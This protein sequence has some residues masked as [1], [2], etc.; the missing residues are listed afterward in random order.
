MIGSLDFAKGKQQAVY[1]GSGTNSWP[2]AYS[3]DL[4]TGKTKLIDDSDAVNYAH[5]KLGEV[6]DWEFVSKR[7]QRVIG[8]YYLPP[9]F[10]EKKKYPTIV[11]YYGGTTPVGRDFG[12]RYPK[13]HYAANGFV[14]LVLQPSGTIG[15]GQEFSAAHVNAWGEITAD[16]IIEG[17]IKFSAQHNF[18]NVD[19]IG[20]MGASYGGFMTMYLL[21]QTD[22]FATAISHAG[23]S[24]ISSYWGEGFWG[25]SYSAEASANSF[26][27]N[28]R[29][30][31]IDKSPLFNA[32]KVVTP[33][34]LLHGADDTNVPVGESIQMFTALKLLG[35][36]VDHIQIKGEDHHIL[37]YGR[38][39]EWTNTILAYF[40]KHLK[41][42]EGWWN[43]M[44]P[45]QNY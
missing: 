44:Y 22:I 27:W 9:N 41:G 33:L 24:S 34:L 30:L 36:P 38:R 12:G 11:Y 45:T 17:T 18:V 31:Y 25:Y 23:I 40:T 13:Q 19:K 14:V 3:I 1:L 4:K 21:T 35:K 7:G 43:E 32:H 37:K 5:V 28:N 8:R 15:F 42:E 6:K 2:K 26:P 10:D 16:E 39:I 29:E 20:C